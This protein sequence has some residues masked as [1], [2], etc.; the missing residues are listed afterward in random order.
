MTK[1]QAVVVTDPASVAALKGL[2][3]ANPEQFA[4]WKFSAA[5]QVKI[6]TRKEEIEVEDGA[7][8]VLGLDGH[9]IQDLSP[10]AGLTNMRNAIHGCKRRR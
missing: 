5:G 3:E 1:N 8:T 2:Y 9:S 7:V 10:L 6:K 4:H